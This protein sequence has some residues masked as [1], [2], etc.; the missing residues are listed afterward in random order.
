MTTAGG[1]RR[2]LAGA[3]ERAPLGRHDGRSGSSLERVVLAHGTP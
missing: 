1:W 3:V 2:A